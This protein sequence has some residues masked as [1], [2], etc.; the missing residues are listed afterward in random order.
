[1]RPATKALMIA[2][3]RE[4]NRG[5]NRGGG[6]RGG[7]SEMEMGGG[8]NE[9]RGGYE[10][11]RNESR[12]GGYNEMRGNYPR[13]AYDRYE[14]NR[15]RNEGYGEMRGEGNNPRYEMEEP[16]NRR[17]Y[18]RDSRGRFRSEMEE[19][20]E[21]QPSMNYPM[22]PPPVYENYGEG[23]R[24][25]FASRGGMEKNDLRMIR[26]GSSGSEMKLDKQTAEEWMESLENEDGTKGPHWTME[27]V[28]QV[29]GQKG[30]QEDPLRAWVALNIMYSDYCSAAKKINANTV[31]F[32]VAMAKAFLDDKDAGAKD[33]LAA[34]YHHIVK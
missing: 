9:M 23:N 18:R 33:K 34:Y 12:N 28:K 22:Y 2:N 3:A 14:G 21:E 17:R 30:W 13:E 8:Y 20:R 16:E 7:R 26:G 10:G 6:N 29:M 31:D 5:G 24:I 19:E 27:Q 25:G 1:M 11:G 4:G 15:M 32:Y